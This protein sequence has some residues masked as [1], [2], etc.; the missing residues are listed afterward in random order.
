MDAQQQLD[1]SQDVSVD[2]SE[3]VWKEFKSIFRQQEQM[4]TF[5]QY[6]GTEVKQS[7]GGRK[8]LSS[9]L[10]KEANWIPY[11]QVKPRR[12]PWQQKLIA[13]LKEKK[14]VDE[15]L[16]IH[17]RFL[18]VPD[19]SLVAAALNEHAAHV[20]DSKS[21]TASSVSHRIETKHKPSE[22][23]MSIYHTASLRQ[24][25]LE[26]KSGGRGGC[27][28]KSHTSSSTGDSD[29]L[30][31]LDDSLKTG[32]SDLIVTSGAYLSLVYLRHLK[33]RQLQVRQ[34]MVKIHWAEK[35]QGI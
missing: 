17:S 23:W 24:E 7:H 1:T 21:A 8:H 34:H 30:E 13:K 26:M 6:D 28:G 16:K 22:I 2:P 3:Q 27:N 15:L 10:R 32:T 9:V 33:V 14:S 5:P 29:S 19:A 25:T 4:K 11:I 20:V 31:L 35:S 18:Q 12:D